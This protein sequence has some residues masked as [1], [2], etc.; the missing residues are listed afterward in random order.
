MASVI[1]IMIGLVESCIAGFNFNIDD[2]VRMSKIELITE[3]H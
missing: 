2:F 3:F 1:F